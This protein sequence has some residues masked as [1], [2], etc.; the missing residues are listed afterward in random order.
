MKGKITLSSEY[1]EQFSNLYGEKY[2]QDVVVWVEADLDIRFWKTIFPQSSSKYN[3]SFRR[4]YDCS[5]QDDKNANG[6]SRIAKLVN[7]GDL[8]PGPLVLICIDSDYRYILEDYSYPYGFIKEND[9]VFETK[10]CSRENVISHPK[11][12]KETVQRATSL[13]SWPGDFDF[14]IFMKD[15][16]KCIYPAHSL[17]LF[18]LKK[19]MKEWSGVNDELLISIKDTLTKKIDYAKK[20]ELD[21]YNKNYFFNDLNGL[22]TEIS[23]RYFNQ[24]LHNEYQEFCEKIKCKIGGEEQIF[25]FIRGHDVYDFVFEKISQKVQETLLQEEKERRRLLND[26]DGIKNLFSSSID[27]RTAIEL[28]TDYFQCQH[29]SPTALTIRQ[30]YG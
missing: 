6:C 5:S 4:S 10:V 13:T 8:Q 7:S 3:F 2:K 14:E 18:F 11:G 22:V 27:I 28:R 25:Y 12:F 29:F 9:Y 30:K 16:S 17:A 24:D 15:F 20:P 19:G 26:K 23:A 21:K 1:M